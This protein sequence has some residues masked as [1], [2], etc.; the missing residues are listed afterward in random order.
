MGHITTDPLGAPANKHSFWVK[1]DTEDPVIVHQPHPQ[2]QRSRG[3]VPH[4]RDVTDNIGVESVYLMYAKNG[5]SRPPRQDD[6]DGR[7]QYCGAIPGPAMVG[8]YFDY[9]IYAM[10]ESYSGSGL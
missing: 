5:G 1:Q 3:S 9:Y 7:R 4:L 10:D 8:D 6:L 2:H